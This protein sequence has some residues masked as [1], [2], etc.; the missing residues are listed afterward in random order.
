MNPWYF[1]SPRYLSADRIP[2]FAEIAPA[3]RQ[4]LPGEKTLFS[5]QMIG[6]FF[7]KYPAGAIGGDA[8]KV[9]YLYGER[10]WSNKFRLRIPRPVYGRVCAAFHGVD[11]WF[12]RLPELKTIRLHMAIPLFSLFFCWSALPFSGCGSAEAWPRCRPF[13]TILLVS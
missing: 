10:E 12:I 11:R 3:A 4:T 1:C 9:Y 8:V 7:N 2:R 5:F 6:S 13:T